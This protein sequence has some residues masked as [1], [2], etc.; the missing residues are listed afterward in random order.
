[1]HARAESRP[2]DRAATEAD[3]LKAAE[4]VLSRGGWT[5]LNVQSLAAEA[6]VDRKL[7]YRYFEG[8]DGVVDRLAERL[9][10]WLGSALAE[11]PAPPPA[12]YRAFV[13]DLLTGYLDALRREPL[14]LRLI[15]WE[16][17][18]DTPL[19]RRLAARRSE[20]IQAWIATRRGDL[21]IPV[22]VDPF[23]INAVLIA[24][25]QGLALAGAASGRFAGL[26]LDDAGWH[27]VE[28][29]LD[30]LLAALPA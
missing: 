10:I 11:R 17:C 2:R 9:E 20:V 21:V 26:D 18:E 13:R 19:L 23:A 7:I 16:A 24:A 30:R 6:G 25:V 12:D 29:A 22:E 4:R 3:I 15:A 27:R 28:R 14:L 1:M 5:Q 8:V